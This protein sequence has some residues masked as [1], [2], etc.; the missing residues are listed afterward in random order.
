MPNEGTPPQDNSPTPPRVGG[1][2]CS[3]DP[4][5]SSAVRGSTTARGAPLVWAYAKSI[6]LLAIAVV[7]GVI[8]LVIFPSDAPVPARSGITALNLEGYFV[9]DNVYVWL[10]DASSS[11]RTVVTVAVTSYSPISTRAVLSL[12]VPLEA[13]GGATR[14]DQRALGCQQR[15][16][17][18]LVTY[19]LS[20]PYHSTYFGVADY[21]EQV[22]FTVP[23]VDYN[24]AANSEYVSATI[25]DVSYY[26][27]SSAR[28]ATTLAAPEVRNVVTTVSLRFPTAARYSWISG[29][30]PQLGGSYVGWSFTNSPG[31]TLVENGVSL[32]TQDEN[33]KLV[34]IAGALLGIAGGALVGAVQEAI[35]D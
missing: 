16:G 20:A 31:T 24:V 17:V 35:R 28:S 27:T 34:F 5:T 25:P 4:D 26:Y 14:C 19:L 3:N 29:S 2:P 22:Q 30:N 33:T 9:P 12:N 13:W 8:A 23:T 7:A 10:S 15:P 18:K 1:A 11:T 32:A 21:Q 6:V